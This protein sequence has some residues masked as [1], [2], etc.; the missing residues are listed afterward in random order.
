MTPEERWQRIEEKHLA[1]AESV[2]AVTRDVHEMQATTQHLQVTMIEM[3]SAMVRLDRK[4]RKG[5]EAILQ[6]I[7]S[8]L[9]AQNGEGE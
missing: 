5:R 4:E 1:L 9:K 7:V 8:Y 6:A 3:Q 2:E